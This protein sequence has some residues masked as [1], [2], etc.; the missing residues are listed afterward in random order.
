M[1]D[2]SPDP[3]G[4]ERPAAAAAE[5]ERDPVTI[6]DLKRTAETFADLA[7]PELMQ[8]AWRTSSE[9]SSASRSTSSPPEV[10]KPGISR[11]SPTPSTCDP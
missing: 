11:S 7:D 10:S 9:R 5:A 2:P 6:D 1:D 3:T 4:P 8:Q